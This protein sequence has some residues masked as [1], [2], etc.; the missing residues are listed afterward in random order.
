M[1]PDRMVVKGKIPEFSHGVEMTGKIL[2]R[3][4]SPRHERHHLPDD[5]VPSLIVRTI[6]EAGPEPKAEFRH[7][8]GLVHRFALFLQSQAGLINHTQFAGLDKVGSVRKP[9]RNSGLIA[10][11]R[12][13]GVA[14]SNLQYLKY[15][16]KGFAKGCIPKVTGEGLGIRS[17]ISKRMVSRR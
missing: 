13:N 17:S 2:A 8:S 11:F 5:P 14:E 1:V 7:Q 10:D 6:E 3:A 16:V 9:M 15:R 4:L 12:V